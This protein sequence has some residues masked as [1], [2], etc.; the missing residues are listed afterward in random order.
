MNM[1]RNAD[2][3]MHPRRFPHYIINQNPRQRF[4]IMGMLMIS[5][6]SWCMTRCSQHHRRDAI[7]QHN[8]FGGSSYMPL[9]P[10]HRSYPSPDTGAFAILSAIVYGT[11]VGDA[12]G[13]PYEF[14]SRG[15]LSAREEAAGNAVRK[16]RD[17]PYPRRRNPAGMRGHGSHDQ[18]AGTWSDDT[19][20]TL[21][22]VASLQEADGRVNTADMLS[23]FRDWHGRGRYAIGGQVFDIG[24]TTARALSSGT[25]QAG[26]RDCGNG[27]LMRIAPLAATGA[28]DEDV[29][30]VSAITHANPLACD[31]CVR[32]VHLLRDVA[33][34]PCEDDEGDRRIADKVLAVLDADGYGGVVARPMDAVRSGGYVIDTLESAVWCLGNRIGFRDCVETAVDL[35][36][37]TDTTAAVTGALAA[38]AY[39]YCDI[40]GEWLACLR[41]REMLEGALRGKAYRDAHLDWADGW[42]WVDGTG[43]SR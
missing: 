33:E 8:I 41:G 15:E 4:G 24:G 14:G 1:G 17:R 7:Y 20:M 13:V 37:D 2:V 22:T 11:A 43:T 26:E 39:G 23:R 5:T 42:R 29:R 10:D 30:S 18:P 19:S 32:F 21:A 3:E 25:G 6:Y 31:A 9:L 36:G 27:S 28:T 12:L 40:P 38:A 34:M 16:S 35:G